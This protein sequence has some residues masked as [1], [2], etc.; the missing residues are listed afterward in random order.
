VHDAEDLVK[1]TEGQ[2]A[3]QPKEE[4]TAAIERLKSTSERVKASALA[5]ARATDRFIRRNPYPSAGVSFG[6]G[7]LLGL[8]LRRR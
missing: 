2:L 3:G 1:A 6:I 8:L 5:G 4:L 7:V